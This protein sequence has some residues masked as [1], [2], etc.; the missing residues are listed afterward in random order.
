MYAA[1]ALSVVAFLCAILVALFAANPTFG[2]LF[3]L[4]WFSFS[5][6]LCGAATASRRPAAAA[7]ISILSALVSLAFSAAVIWT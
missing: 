4:F 7:A 3:L 6:I 1:V 2:L 5:I